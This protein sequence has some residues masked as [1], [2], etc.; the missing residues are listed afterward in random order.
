MASSLIRLTKTPR[1]MLLAGLV[2]VVTVSATLLT[3]CGDDPATTTTAS[4]TTTPTTAAAP[5]PLA[6][7][8]HF[9]FVREVGDGTL[10]L[11]PAG[12]LSGEAALA[13]ARE[14]GVVGQAEDLPN[15][16]YIDNDETDAVELVVADTASIALLALDA[17]DVPAETSLTF[18]EFSDAWNGRA[19]SERFYGFVT[20]DLPMHVIVSGGMVVSAVQQYLP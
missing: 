16:F 5:A 1:I 11:D 12:F 20:G 19:D 15:D 8:E 4:T 9:G 7:G 2:V 6:D 13:A 14:D 3:S 10:T 18:E 17:S